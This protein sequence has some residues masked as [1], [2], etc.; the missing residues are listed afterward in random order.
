MTRSKIAKMLV[1]VGLAAAGGT[2]TQRA[3]VV[4]AAGKPQA[5]SAKPAL[6]D[7]ALLDQYCVTCHNE[8]LKTADLMLDKVNL[9]DIASNAEVLERVVRKLRNGQ[10]PPEG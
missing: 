1:V 10:M 3:N 5:P 2:Y 7:R 4:A 6:P 8:K 9:S